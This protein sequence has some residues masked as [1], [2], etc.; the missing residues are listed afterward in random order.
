MLKGFSHPQINILK[1]ESRLHYRNR[2]QLHY[3]KKKN[4]IGF[5]KNKSKFIL[6]VPYCQII[7]KELQTEFDRVNKDWRSLTKKSQ[8]HIELY[9]PHDKIK[10][11]IDKPYAHGGFSQVNQRANKIML[12][13]IEQL[14]KNI[15]T[16]HIIDL[17]AGNGNISDHLNFEQRIC[18]DIY[19]HPPA[20]NFFNIDLFD[21]DSLSH[22]KVISDNTRC[23]LLIIDPPRSGFKGL[24]EWIDLL[25]PSHLLYISCHPQTM[26]RDLSSLDQ[27]HIKDATMI[28]LFP[29]TYHFEA[30]CLIELSKA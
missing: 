10:V 26:V 27:I 8:G 18:V 15:K 22:F 3:D 9:K 14:T 25:K 21:K 5:H 2:I 4:S 29:S 1:D 30:M 23:D 16:N 19:A 24:K 12:N 11:S 13:S 20:Q 7:E 6:N 28:D 17:F